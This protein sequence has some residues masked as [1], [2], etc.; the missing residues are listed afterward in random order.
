MCNVCLRVKVSVFPDGSWKSNN[1]WRL[2]KQTWS[3]IQG[4]EAEPNIQSESFRHAGKCQQGYCREGLNLRAF[5]KYS[6]YYLHTLENNPVWVQMVLQDLWVRA[7][8]ACQRRVLKRSML[9]AL[10]LSNYW[11][12]KKKTNKELSSPESSCSG[13]KKQ[14]KRLQSSGDTRGWTLC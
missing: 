8:P 11:R 13:K 10:P 7:W 4:G 3:V 6:D 1:C 9:F 12:K 14:R 5:F 2:N